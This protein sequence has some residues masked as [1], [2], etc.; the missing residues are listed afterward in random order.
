[1]SPFGTLDVYGTWDNDLYDYN[2]FVSTTEDIFKN[3]HE[4]LKDLETQLEQ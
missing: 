2:Y 4:Q 1:M 3:L